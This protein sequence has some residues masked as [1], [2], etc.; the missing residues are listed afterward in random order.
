MRY[1]IFVRAAHPALAPAAAGASPAGMEGPPYIAV[2]LSAMPDGRTDN[3]FSHNP[4]YAW[5]WVLHMC[6]ETAFPRT[7]FLVAYL[8]HVRTPRPLGG[9]V[10]DLKCSWK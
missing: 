4:P 7:W 8:L 5:P 1:R 10:T 6:C 3:I 2:F 9:P